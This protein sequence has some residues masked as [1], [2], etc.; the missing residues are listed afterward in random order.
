MPRESLITKQVGFVPCRVI[1]PVLIPRESRI[2]VVLFGPSLRVPVLIPRESRIVVV[3]FGPLSRVPVLIPRESRIVV[4]Q[5]FWVVVLHSTAEAVG[6]L[7]ATIGNAMLVTIN[8]IRI[9]IL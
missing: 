4:V 9:F 8:R 1:V 3:L 2:V 5:F 6:T 7:T